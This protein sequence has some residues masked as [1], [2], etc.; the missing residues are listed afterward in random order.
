VTFG[1]FDPSAPLAGLKLHPYIR[2]DH[3]RRAIASAADQV[4]QARVPKW[5]RAAQTA[6]T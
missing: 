4:N 3:A 2:Q 5:V 1:D 6:E